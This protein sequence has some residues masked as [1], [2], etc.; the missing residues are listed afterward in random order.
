MS[1]KVTYNVHLKYLDQIKNRQNQYP[2][3]DF[4]NAKVKKA[5]KKKEINTLK[6]EIKLNNKNI[7]IVKN[8][9]KLK[10]KNYN[11][12][13]INEIENIQKQLLNGLITKNNELKTELKILKS[14]Q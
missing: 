7:T 14:A 4:N 10:K 1:D 13:Y 3:Y 9:L 12:N 2:T 8:N 11:D 5:S 6:S